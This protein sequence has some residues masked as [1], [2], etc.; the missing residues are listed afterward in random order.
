[1]I[2][3]CICTT[4]RR[5]TCRVLKKNRYC[6]NI[7]GRRTFKP[8][9]HPIQSLESVEIALDEFEAIRLCDLEGKNQIDASEVMG[10]SRGT[11]Q[12]LLNSGRKKIV[13]ALLNSKAINI[14]DTYDK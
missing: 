11:V 3:L 4:K 8:T 1:M 6:R 5:G 14:K 13:D 7:E 9:G 10:V 12:R 2:I